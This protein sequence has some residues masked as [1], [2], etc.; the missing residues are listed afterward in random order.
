MY[1][2]VFWK[3]FTRA[4]KKIDAETQK[5]IL[6]ALERISAD[7]FRDKDVRA[8]A[9]TKEPYFRLRVSRW[10]IMYLIIHDDK[11]IEVVDLF[12]KKSDADYRRRI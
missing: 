10:R 8:L 6:D 1:E 7:P 3:R 12:M 2:I 11:T 5:Q 4:F 9:G